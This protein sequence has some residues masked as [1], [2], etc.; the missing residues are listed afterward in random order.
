[1]Y[2]LKEYQ[3]MILFDFLPPLPLPACSTAMLTA[4]HRVARRAPGR[5]TKEG[6]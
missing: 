1:M 3:I 2:L 4:W 6:I 5:L